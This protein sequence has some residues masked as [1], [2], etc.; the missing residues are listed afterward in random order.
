MVWERPRYR[1]PARTVK[2]LPPGPLTFRTPADLLVPSDHRE[3]PLTRADFRP[4]E[5]SDR[6]A[7]RDAFRRDPPDIS[8]YTFSNL[9]VWR[10]SRRTRIRLR[11]DGFH[12]L[13]DDHGH[14]IL[15]PPAGFADRRTAWKELVDLF[16]SD[17]AIAA[18]AKIPER[19]LPILAELGLSAL[20]DR[21]H[22]D[23]LY[24]ASDLAELKGRRYD[25]KR[26]FLRKFAEA[27]PTARALPYSAPWRSA[28]LDLAA[29]WAERRTAE[30][31]ECAAQYA[32]E[33]AAI[34]DYLDHIADLECCGCVL[35][36]DDRLLGFTFGE[37][38]NPSTFVIHFEKADPSAPGAYQAV[39]REFVRMAVLGRF[40]FVNREQD[41]GA[42]GIRK[43]KLSYHPCAFVRKHRVP[44]P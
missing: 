15:L 43:A 27:F 31:P 3:D 20:E 24:H 4:I 40:A 25:G 28:C 44:R 17:S 9:F 32:E 11:D 19:D 41:L 36:A 21:D 29:A 8:E 38:L 6:D 18:I 26:W 14:D 34:T 35:V 22:W 2:P 7:V 10:R 39:N 42:E 33:T 12:L 23:Y 1:H 16:R 5:L 30:H 13:M 37:P